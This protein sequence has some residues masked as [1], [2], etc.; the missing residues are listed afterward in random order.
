MLQPALKN[1]YCIFVN[2]LYSMNRIYGLLV[3]F[4][5]LSSCKTRESASDTDFNYMKNIEEIATQ[6]SE[7]STSSTIQ[8]GDQLR[9]FVSARNMEVAR[10]FNKSYY[11]TPSPT[12]TAVPDAEQV[13]L[14]STDGSIDFPVLGKINT[15]G[16]TLEAVK[17]ELQS[18]ISDYI[19]DPT[20]TVSLANFRVTVLGEVARPNEYLVVDGEATLLNALGM[21]GDLTTYARRDNI[22]M[23][24]RIDGEIHKHRINMADANFINSPYFYLKQGDV[25]YVSANETKEKQARLDP[26]TNVYIAVAGTLIGLA[27]I[28]ITIFKN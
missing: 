26:R 10:P 13:Y 8:K 1:Q 3:V 24:R 22:L 25:I 4:C 12:A 28:F 9:I 17:E 5:V 18:R 6:Y 7:K 15:N 20:V 21:A 19:I 16:K 11:T 27:G 2:Y 14:V 23:V